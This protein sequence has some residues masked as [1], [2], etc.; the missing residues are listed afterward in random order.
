MDSISELLQHEL[1]DLYSAENQLL[2][3]MPKMAKKVTTQS[4]KDAMALHLE[5]TKKQVERL[6][7][8]G[9]ILGM[10][11][12]T[13]TKCMAMEGL[14]KEAQEI[15]SE[16]EPSAATDVAIVGS[17]Q[18]IEH[19]EIA[20]YGT[21]RTLAKAIKQKEVADLISETLKEEGDTDKILTKLCEKEI[22]PAALSAADEEEDEGDDDDAG[23]MDEGG[24]GEDDE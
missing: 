18:R 17:A 19:Y 2:K 7:R 12:M 14:I 5:Q 9:E 16:E 13:G 4:L 6:T 10:K 15:I 20:G 23:E 11:K 21:C 8:M 1:K 3:A 24:E 22:I